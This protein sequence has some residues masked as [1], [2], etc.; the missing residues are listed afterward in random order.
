MSAGQANLPT[1]VRDGAA[2]SAKV[3]SP[4]PSCR[5][6]AAEGASA[7][8]SKRGRRAGKVVR[9]REVARRLICLLES[10]A[11]PPKAKRRHQ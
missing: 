9:Q 4:A 5:K 3:T 8:A 2:E 11:T 6:G 1:N 10:V 7:S